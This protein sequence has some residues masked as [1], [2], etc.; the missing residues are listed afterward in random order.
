MATEPVPQSVCS[1]S[2]EPLKP[3]RGVRQE[4]VEFHIPGLVQTLENSSQLASLWEVAGGEVE[5]SFLPV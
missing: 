3:P 1:K 4:S 2:S 5:Y